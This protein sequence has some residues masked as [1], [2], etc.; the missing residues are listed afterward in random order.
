MMEIVVIAYF[1]LTCMQKY[2][3]ESICHNITRAQQVFF[4]D[5]FGIERFNVSYLTSDNSTKAKCEKLVKRL[6]RQNN[7][8]ITPNNCEATTPNFLAELN[9]EQLKSVSSNNYYK[10][11]CNLYML[12]H[13]G[14]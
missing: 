3:N 8:I 1:I 6:R 4:P 12:F 5:G 11:E 14:M 10:Q 7:V 9:Y 2:F 13:V